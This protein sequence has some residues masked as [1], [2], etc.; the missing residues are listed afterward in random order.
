MSVEIAFTCDSCGQVGKPSE[1]MSRRRRRIGSH[2]PRWEKL[3][4]NER[5]FD[6]CPS[7]SRQIVEWI[8]K[9]V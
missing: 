4:F 8:K 7:C 5:S 3:Y 2:P 1:T 6:L 9:T